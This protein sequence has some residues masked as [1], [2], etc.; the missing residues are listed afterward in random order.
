[1][2]EKKNSIIA[3]YGTVPVPS[4]S[5]MRIDSFDP[6]KSYM[7]NIA[8]SDDLPVVSDEF[9]SPDIKEGSIAYH[10]VF[11]NIYY[12]SYYRFSTERFINNLL[13][14]DANPSIAAHIIHVDSCGGEAF[15]CH[16]AYEVVRR[17][18]KPCYALVDT[19]AASA[20]YYLAAGADKIYSSSIFSS[21]GCIGV[22]AVLYDDAGMLEKWGIKE[23]EYYSSY[24]PRKNKI[25]NDAEK[26]DGEEFVKTYLDPLAEAFINDVKSARPSASEAALEG[27]TYYT[28]EAVAAGLV[29]GQKTLEDLI[30]DI[31]KVVSKKQ[32]RQ[33]DINKIPFEQ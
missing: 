1:M 14:A 31:A 21:V 24:S 22:M 17:L 29:D 32:S 25:F 4:E 30:S 15:G 26:G 19:T 27:E 18:K 11:G 23:H 9:Y 10:P 13:S 3:F 16:E 8:L 2:P 5:S 7:D 6:H 33:I 12:R 20:G 28:E